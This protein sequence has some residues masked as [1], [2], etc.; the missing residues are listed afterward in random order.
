MK[1]TDENEYMRLVEEIS[2][3][4]I[5]PNGKM[6]FWSKVNAVNEL[7]KRTGVNRIKAEQD[8]FY[9]SHNTTEK[10]YNENIEK[11]EQECKKRLQELKEQRQ[12]LKEQQR[13]NWA[14]LAG[15]VASSKVARCPRCH[16]TSITYGGN[17]PSVGRAIIGDA[18]AGPAGA[19]IG[20]MSGKKGYAVCLNCGKRWKI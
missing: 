12:E 16:S 9:C 4:Y 3:K 1:V 15:I 2:N 10:E 19:V 17:R 14:K 5:S 6:K 7:I 13:E 11:R 20:G 18:V 8:I